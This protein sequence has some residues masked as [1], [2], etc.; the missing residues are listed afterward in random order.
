MPRLFFFPLQSSKLSRSLFLMG[1]GHRNVPH[2][3]GAS[4]HP[5]S[6]LCDLHAA[7]PHARNPGRVDGRHSHL[8]GC[9][10]QGWLR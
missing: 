10:Y 1:R 6:N 7:Q 9:S 5:L 8:Q 4:D 2:E 3:H